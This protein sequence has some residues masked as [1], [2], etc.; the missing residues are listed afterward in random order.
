[1]K[2]YVFVC[3]CCAAANL[4]AGLIAPENVEREGDVIALKTIPRVYRDRAQ[5]IDKRLNE[6]CAQKRAEYPFICGKLVVE[7]APDAS[8]VAC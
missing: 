3:A 2:G 6:N 7:D 8:N 5:E 4:F 1:M